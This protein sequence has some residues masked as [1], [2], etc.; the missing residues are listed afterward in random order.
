[1]LFHLPSR[2]VE[3]HNF[4]IFPKVSKLRICW[5]IF[6]VELQSQKERENECMVISLQSCRVAKFSKLSK[7]L[8][9]LNML[10]HFHCRVVELEKERKSVYGHFPVELQSCQILKTFQRSQKTE[11]NGSFSAQSCRV[12]N[13]EKNQC[14]VICLQS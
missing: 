6:T 10:V 2:V 14:M 7:G 4:P 12:R 8:K 5:F 13:G 11:N 3:L 9:K 1:M